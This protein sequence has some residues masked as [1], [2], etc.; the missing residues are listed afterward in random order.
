MSIPSDLGRYFDYSRPVPIL[1][2]DAGNVIGT[3]TGGRLGKLL[4][5]SRWVEVEPSAPTRYNSTSNTGTTID[6]ILM[7]TAPHFLKQCRWTSTILDD[8]KKLHIS[9]LSDH[10]MVQAKAMF[11]APTKAGTGIPPIHYYKH[12]MF[13]VFYDALAHQTK[14]KDIGDPCVMKAYLVEIIKAV[15]L[16]VRK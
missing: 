9:G 12:Q 6:R 15:S 3:S 8:P 4:K 14:V 10:G 1:Q 13:S 16:V 7:N 11:T 5:D 2:S